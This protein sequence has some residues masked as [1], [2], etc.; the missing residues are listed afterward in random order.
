MNTGMPTR[1]GQGVGDDASGS[2]TPMV[3]VVDGDIAVPKSLEWLIATSGWDVEHLASVEALLERPR[4][5]V[6]TCLVLDRSLP[7][8]DG[9]A[10]QKRLA[11]ARPAMPVIVITGHQDVT[12][13]VQ[14]MKAGAIECLVK[15]LAHATVVEAIS[16]G[17]AQSRDAGS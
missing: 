3:Y 14:V 8:G 16:Q 9:P 10:L 4:V 13:T 1:L 2:A 15:P 6:P 17:L 5:C 12:L 11:V 7:N